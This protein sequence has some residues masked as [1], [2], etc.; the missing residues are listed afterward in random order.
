K[1]YIIDNDLGV[2]AFS[3]GLRSADMVVGFTR[4]CLEY[5][6][7]DELQGIAAYQIAQIINGQA[8]LNTLVYGVLYGLQFVYSNV[9]KLFIVENAQGKQE[10]M[11]IRII[12]AIFPLWLVSYIGHFFAKIIK[13]II[14]REN[15]FE[16][17]ATAVQLTRNPEGIASV[18]QNSV[19]DADYSCLIFSETFL[20]DLEH[21]LFTFGK[22]P[23]YEFKILHTHPDAK[24]RIRNILPH[25][26]E[27]RLPKNKTSFQKNTGQTNFAPNLNAAVLGVAGSLMQHAVQP[28]CDEDYWFQAARDTEKSPIIPVAMLMQ[29]HQ[30]P[31][32]C[33][34]IVE[35]FRPAWKESIHELLNHPVPNERLFALLA[36][37]LPNVRLQIIGE[38]NV[39]SYQ[40]FLQDIIKADQQITLFEHCVYA[41][42]SGSLATSITIE[43]LPAIAK[44]KLQK[45]ISELLMLTAKHSS[46]NHQAE[47][48]FQAACKY[49]DVPI[50]SYQDTITLS[51]LPPLLYRLN[52]LSLSDKQELLAA[53]HVIVDF[54][55][56]R[57]SDEKNWIDAMSIALL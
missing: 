20:Q 30:N 7:R 37:A 6:D 19:S 23:V 34:D 9:A 11:D 14:C 57:T 45:E 48:A 12:I 1:I 16:S 18:L 15:V 4:G 43:F 26:R 32:V 36:T 50:S 35:T 40:T 31:K 33:L 44:Q 39:K 5:L 53:M 8:R 49:C 41:A 21:L 55:Q 38:A 10:I 3:A 51:Q 46:N 42:V 22:N 28:I 25:W 13:S 17:D 47:Q 56:Q 29:H 54:D 27:N 52:R 2:N 24:K